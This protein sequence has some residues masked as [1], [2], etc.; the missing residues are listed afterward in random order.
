M[1]GMMGSMQLDQAIQLDGS[2]LDEKGILY[3]NQ[4]LNKIPKNS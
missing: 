1:M 3:I 4:M 2:K